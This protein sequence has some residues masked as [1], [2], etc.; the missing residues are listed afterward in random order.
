LSLS[1][2]L[3]TVQQ[4]WQEYKYGLNGRPP[5]EM[6]PN[7]YKSTDT[8]RRYFN[9]RQVIWRQVKRNAQRFNCPEENAVSQLEEFRQR[10][11]SVHLTKSLNWLSD[12]ILAVQS[13]KELWEGGEPNLFLK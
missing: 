5:V 12:R 6:Q 10:G 1:R 9:R 2:S 4:L 11:D 13:G 3:T 8:D 7:K